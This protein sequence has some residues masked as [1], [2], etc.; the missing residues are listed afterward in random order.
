M[1]FHNA[2]PSKNTLSFFGREIHSILSYPTL[3]ISYFS[4]ILVFCFTSNPCD[5][6]F[7]EVYCYG[8]ISFHARDS[9]VMFFE[10]QVI[11]LVLHFDTHF[12]CVPFLLHEKML[13]TFQLVWIKGIHWFR[14]FFFK[15]K[16]HSQ[17]YCKQRLGFTGFI[18]DIKQPKQATKHSL[19]PCSIFFITLTAGTPS[20]LN[21]IMFDDKYFYNND[22]KGLQCWCLLRL[23][24][25]NNFSY[26]KKN[27]KKTINVELNRP[28]HWHKMFPK[29]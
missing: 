14:V 19:V 16:L 23:N 11:H 9:C 25:K 10:G 29:I 17:I 12:V 1:V 27:N 2:Q 15:T 13:N 3:A 21:N 24:Q 18:R 22:L 8:N 6:H 26:G 20:P 28:Q 5:K 4:H 7:C